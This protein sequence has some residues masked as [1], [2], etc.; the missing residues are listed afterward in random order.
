MTGTIKTL[1]DRG[2]GFIAREGEAYREML[3]ER[4]RAAGL[5]SMVVFDDRY[6]DLGSLHQLI[7]SADVVILP[8]DTTDQATSGVLVD[9]VAAG[10][11]VVATDFP[12]ARELLADG[13]GFLVRQ[14]NAHEM[15]NVLRLLL[16]NEAVRVEMAAAARRAAIPLDWR[17]VATAYATVAHEVLTRTKV[18]T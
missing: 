18:R 2:Y 12:H 9:A 6:R 4:V 13:A 11:P 5:E 1:T 8:Y 17:S 3:H 7:A 14:R 10:R 15:A 16:T